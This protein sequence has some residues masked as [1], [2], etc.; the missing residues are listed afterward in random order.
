MKTPFAIHLRRLLWSPLRLGAN[1]HVRQWMEAIRRSPEVQARRLREILEDLAETDFGRQ[2]GLARVRTI[3]DLRQALP[4]AGFERVAPYVERLK[5]GHVE[6]LFPRGTR[7]HMF[8]MTSGTTGSPKAVPITDKVLE[9]YRAGWH[10][11]GARA[12]AD[13]FDA[14]GAPVLQITSRIDEHMTPSGIPAGAISGLMAHAPSRIIR[15]VYVMPPEASKA[16]DTAAKYY[17]A[18]RLGLCVRRVLPVTANPSTLLGLARAMD[19]RKE[20]LIRDVADGTL[21]ADLA[22]DRSSRRRIEERL[23]PLPQRARH[24]EDVVK[25]TG[26]LYPKDAWELPLIATWKGG[27]LGLYL[28]EMP[29]YWGSAPVRDIGLVASEGRFSIPLQTDGSAGI[30]EIVGNFY[31]FVPEEEIQSREPTALLSH[32]VEVG[33]RYFLILTTP[34][35]LVRY[36]I[37]D[38]VQVVGRLGPTPLIEFLNKGE[39]VSNLT[40]EKITE[41]QVTSAVS[42]SLDR[43]NLDVRNYCLAPTWDRVPYY[44][45]LVEERDVPAT[46]APQLA[47]AV[48]TALRERNI[49]YE[50]KRSGGRLRAIRVKS[51]P[52]GSWQTFDAQAV[53]ACGGRIEQYKH[54]FLVNKVDFERRFDIRGCWAPT[55]EGTRAPCE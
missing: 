8:A 36:H 7:I 39:H 49:E 32:E 19:Q 16:S 2:H 27:T 18:S 5:T 46:R 51:I 10:L 33:H 55:E 25:R 43:L 48:D 13:H 6:A 4:I 45:L 15:R 28:R 50:A 23:A 53:A 26:R 21:A 24:L 3:E 22:L 31:E 17:L 20:Q 44:S 30:L 40:G 12:L 37:S 35:G 42:A 38:L 1:R 41:F 52:A 11:W 14:F 34:G 47:A 54:K 29:L 9:A